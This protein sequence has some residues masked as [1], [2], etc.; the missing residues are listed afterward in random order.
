MGVAEPEF[1][2]EDVEVVGV[3]VV[4]LVDEALVEF[5]TTK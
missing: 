2:I 4:K 1:V 5:V 3:E